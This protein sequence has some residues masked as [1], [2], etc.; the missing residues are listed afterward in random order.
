MEKT[1][2]AFGDFVIAKKDDT[3]KV[4][5]SGI[6]IATSMD[7]LVEVTVLSVGCGEEI[8]S[9]KEGDNILIPY[10]CPTVKHNN[11]TYYHISVNNIIGKI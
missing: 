7:E 8:Q 10:N 4:T 6:Q 9:I 2:K 11:T 1:F 5:S 3:K